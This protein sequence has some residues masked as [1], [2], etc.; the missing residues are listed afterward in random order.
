MNYIKT[1]CFW[2]S[3]ASC[4]CQG[5]PKHLHIDMEEMTLTRTQQL[6]SVTQDYHSCWGMGG[7]FAVWTPVLWDWSAS[8]GP[9]W[10]SSDDLGPRVFAP[11]PSVSASSPKAP[12][13]TLLQ[14]LA[15]SG[16]REK[17]QT[18]RWATDLTWYAMELQRHWSF[19]QHWGPSP[20]ALSV[21]ERCPKRLRS[22]RST[23]NPWPPDLDL[24]STTWPWPLSSVSKRSHTALLNSDS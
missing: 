6:T 11:A 5:C 22:S 21:S 10:P 16:S 24:C 13:T 19:G 7:H 23:A 18:P 14:L 15:L 4:L 12:R 3:S 17:T 20:A 1:Y 2:C 9:R 8:P